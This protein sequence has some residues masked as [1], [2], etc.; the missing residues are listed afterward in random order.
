MLNSVVV[1]LFLASEC[2]A[3]SLLCAGHACA[4]TKAAQSAEK[5]VFEDSPT[6]S[7][8]CVGD[9]GVWSRL[10]NRWKCKTEGTPDAGRKC[11]SGS[12]CDG[13]CHVPD[14]NATVG[15]E[16]FGVCSE[17][18]VDSGCLQFVQGGKALPEICT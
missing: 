3:L 11:K 14:R 9:A 18:Y 4:D 13:F 7:A 16:R 10:E 17:D 15:A 6:P 2:L 12:E 1:S 5:P 8:A